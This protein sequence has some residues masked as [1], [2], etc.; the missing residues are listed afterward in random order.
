MHH[1]N[2]QLLFIYLPVIE[3]LLTIPIIYVDIAATVAKTLK[4]MDIIPT[5]IKLLAPEG[6]S[7]VVV[8]FYDIEG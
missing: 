4:S 3:V 8:V 5:I 7:V 6:L 1:V 2:I